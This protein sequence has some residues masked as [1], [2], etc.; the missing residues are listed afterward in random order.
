MG[1]YNGRFFDGGYSGKS[2]GRDYIKEQIKNTET[3]IPKIKD[4][5][6]FSKSYDEFNFKEECVIYCDIPYQGTK[7]Y[8]TS[9]DF[10]YIKFWEWC[11]KMKT[12][13]H[14]IF[15]SEYNAPDDF[16]C[17]WEKEIVNSMNQTKTYKPIE[18]L[19]TL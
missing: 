1:S 15:I 7:Q 13:G 14:Q 5:K 2:S 12:D 19:F 6:F 16:K 17:I 11:R 4:I 9:K 18:K 3:Q 8:T 10:D